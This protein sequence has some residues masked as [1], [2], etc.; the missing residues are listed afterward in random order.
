MAVFHPVSHLAS[1]ARIAVGRRANCLLRAL[2]G[3]LATLGWARLYSGIAASEEQGEGT[4]GRISMDVDNG[5]K[6]ELLFAN[7]TH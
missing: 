1:K 7:H 6:G 5:S 2:R 4:G 3:P